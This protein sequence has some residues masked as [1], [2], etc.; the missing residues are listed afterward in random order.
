MAAGLYSEG[1]CFE[2]SSAAIRSWCFNV[3]PG[4]R[5]SSCEI[6]S[7]VP[8][9]SFVD[10]SATLQTTSYTPSLPACD[11][12]TDNLNPIPMA[13]ALS[14]AIVLVWIGIWAFNQVRE[15]IRGD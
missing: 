4:E 10:N 11:T 13:F 14:G 7:G 5:F 6:V 1:Y 9:I 3:E 8:E 12:D 2:D 15:T